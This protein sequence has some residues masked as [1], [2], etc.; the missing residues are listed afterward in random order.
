MGRRTLANTFP[1]LIPERNFAFLLAN[2]FQ[3]LKSQA[4]HKINCF[5]FHNS[6]FD[7]KLTKS[8]Y[9]KNSIQIKKNIIFTKVTDKKSQNFIDRNSSVKTL[10]SYTI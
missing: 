3:T 2:V 9:V 8:H 5:G 1:E 7:V 10:R 6:T 4:V